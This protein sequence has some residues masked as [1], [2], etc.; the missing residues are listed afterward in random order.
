M[1]TLLHGNFSQY[2]LHIS[3]SFS[4]LSCIG[5]SYRSHQTA[6]CW[7]GSQMASLSGTYHT[8]VKMLLKLNTKGAKN[9]PIQIISNKLNRACRKPLYD[10]NFLLCRATSENSGPTWGSPCIWRNM[11]S[12]NLNNS[13]QGSNHVLL[14]HH[15]TR[16]VLLGSQHNQRYA[17]CRPEY[18]IGVCLTLRNVPLVC[19]RC[20][21]LLVRH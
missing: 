1:L 4:C 19:R 3:T 21:A 12:N 13:L 17:M 6:G 2:L 20:G 15:P 11:R 9:S 14:R 16:Q 7:S 18:R 5:D 10:I 8:Y